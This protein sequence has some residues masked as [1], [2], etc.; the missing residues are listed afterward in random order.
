MHGPLKVSGLAVHLNGKAGLGN[1]IA[2][3]GADDSGTE[4]TV[5]LRIK[6]QFGQALAAPEAECPAAGRPRK[7]AFLEHRTGCLSLCLGQPHPG[8]FG[9]GVGHRGNNPSCEH[10]VKASGYLRCYLALVTGFVGQHGLADEITN[11]EDVWD[12]G[13]LLVINRNEAVLVHLDAGSGCID[14]MAV[15]YTAERQ[16]YA[17]KFCRWR[18]LGPVKTDREPC[19]G[20]RN[21]A[22][23]GA[24]VEVLALF[25]QA[26]LQRP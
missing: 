18:G 23:P 10:A 22:D 2:G 24:E 13:A 21:R 6:Q 4:Q 16:Q 15:G 3:V 1:E 20:S 26:P 11:G 5:C 8:N 19:R 7:N 12:I 25:L 14:T 17:V 9:V